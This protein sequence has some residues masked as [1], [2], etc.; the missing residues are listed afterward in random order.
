MSIQAWLDRY[1]PLITDTSGCTDEDIDAFER[2]WQVC[3]REDHKR[4]LKRFGR[5]VGHSIIDLLK[6]TNASYDLD[7]IDLRSKS[8]M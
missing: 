5:G 1:L 3:F 7:T 6:I 8:I 2:K 4:F